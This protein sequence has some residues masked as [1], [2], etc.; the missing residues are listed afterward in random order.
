[1]VYQYHKSLVKGVESLL[2]FI[3]GFVTAFQK[4]KSKIV[5][6]K[7]K[8]IIAYYNKKKQLEMA[9]SIT[10]EEKED[11]SQEEKL[12]D[13]IEGNKAKNK[14]KKEKLKVRLLSLGTAIVAFFETLP[15]FLTVIIWT[16][17]IICVIS[18]L[19]VV[20]SIFTSVTESLSG[21]PVFKPDPEAPPVEYTGGGISGPLEWTDEELATRGA[22]LTEYEKNLYRMGIFARKAIEG[23]GGGK[24][25]SVNNTNTGV[26]FMLGIISI[27]N[28]MEF[29]K[30]GKNLDISKTPSDIGYNSYGYGFLG[31]HYTDKLSN[32]V[33]GT[34]ASNVKAQ[35]T[36]TSGYNY[37]AQ[38]APWGMVMSVVH[39]EQKI[40]GFIKVKD[41]AV[42]GNSQNT[43]KTGLQKIDEAMARWGIQN[44]REEVKEVIMLCLAAAQYHGA[45]PFEHDDY[46]NFLCAVY[47]ATSDNDAERS[48]DKWTLELKYFDE[49]SFRYAVLGT[50][51]HRTI[52]QYGTPDNLPRNFS[53]TRLVLNGTRL[54]VPLWTYLWQKY[55]TRDDFKKAWQRAYN[56]SNGGVQDRVLNFHYGLNG[57]LQAKHIEK[58]LSSKLIGDPF[59][60]GNSSANTNEVLRYGEQLIGLPYKMVSVTYHKVITHG[61]YVNGQNVKGVF[62]GYEDCSSF[63]RACY[64]HVGKQLPRTAQEQ[65][66]ALRGSIVCNTLDYSKMQPGDVIFFWGTYGSA[67]STFEKYRDPTSAPQSVKDSNVTHVGLYFGN[68]LMIHESSGA[69]GTVVVPLD[70]SYYISHFSSVRRVP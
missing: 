13:E 56:F 62:E 64:K 5:E 22:A 46:I 49:N 42:I 14:V 27:E 38:Y 33:N 65:S 31:L 36:P 23:Y 50:N 28:G 21:I 51:K 7:N 57:Y 48:W 68:K 52:S 26:L 6:N 58:M 69:G 54:E 11:K 70:N 32:Y 60:V 35:Y 15:I 4:G 29:Y 40:S 1:M 63:V 8:A 10:S 2:S 43:G 12:K 44:N 3:M 34:I 17:V 47:C 19:I 24:L 55:G 25:L 16:V 37:E 41:T 66:D 61:K 59:A 9:S 67:A 39:S 53:S 20:L 30:N 45:L 18:I